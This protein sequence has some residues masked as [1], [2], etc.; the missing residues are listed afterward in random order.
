MDSGIITGVVTTIVLGIVV[1]WIFISS[2]RYH[3]AKKKRKNNI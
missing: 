1:I 2:K 3:D